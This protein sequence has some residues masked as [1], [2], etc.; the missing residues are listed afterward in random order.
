VVDLLLLLFTNSN[1]KGVE[2]LKLFLSRCPKNLTFATLI[3]HLGD[4]LGMDAFEIS[5]PLI[6][7]IRWNTKPNA[8]GNK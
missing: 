3:M 7:D 5:K 4:L 1:D 8:N 2:Q 6:K